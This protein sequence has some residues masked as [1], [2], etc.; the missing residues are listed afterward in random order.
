M[1]AAIEFLVTPEPDGGFCACAEVGDTS[2]F[3]EGDSLDELYAMI[4][5]ALRLYRAETGESEVPFKMAFTGR[6][7]AA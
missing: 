4:E 1:S 5:D 6:P 7:L 3:T 2:I